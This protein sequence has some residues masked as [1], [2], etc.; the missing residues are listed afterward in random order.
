MS[1]FDLKGRVRPHSATRGA[2]LVAL[3]ALAVAAACSS[4]GTQTPSSSTGSASG[5][6]SAPPTAAPSAPAGY[7]TIARGAHP[8]ARPEFDTGRLDPTRVLH[9]LSLVF[10]LSPEQKADRDA[11]LDEIQR[12]GSPSYH[13][14]LT[15]EDYAARFGAQADDIS[16]ASS[17]LASQGMTVHE[18]SRLGARVTFTGTV[19]QIEAAFQTEM[20]TYYVAATNALRDGAPSFAAR[21]PRRARARRPQRARLLPAQH[22]KP[23]V[24]VVNPQATCPAGALN[25]TTGTDGI[26][27][28]DWSVIYDVGPLYNPGIAGTQITGAGVT[29][30]VVGV[31]EISQ[32][33]LTAFRTRYGLASNPITMTLVPN[34][35]AAQARQRRRA[36]RPSSTPSG[37]APSRRTR[38]ST[39]STRARATP[40]S[41]TRSY[42]AIEQNYGAVLS[43]S[44]GGCEEG[45]TTADADVLEVYGS[46]ASLEGISYL[47]SSG[48][49]GAAA[50]PRRG[51]SLGQHARV[52]PGRHGGRGHRFRHHSE[53]TDLHRRHRYGAA[54]PRPSGTSFTTPTRRTAWRRAAAASAR[55]S[56]GRATR[57]R[58]PLV[59]PWARFRR[60]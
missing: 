19:A 33:D 46:A 2:P 29:I 8:L 23:Q 54:A 7:V 57:A 9:N 11:L 56:R 10:K 36:S 32:T 40:T 45:A 12:P 21:R 13:K 5:P 42:Y 31:T 14:W 35:G 39:T 6:T 3:F 44:W 26:A 20:H 17:W 51:G 37:R 59:R 38:P 25:C 55:S 53:P 16:R 15:P 47:A 22:R 24:R 43:E 27:P 30:A 58:S 28:P 1:S 49:D 50:L 41:T 18:P 4:S 48:D 60:G 34:T 52:V